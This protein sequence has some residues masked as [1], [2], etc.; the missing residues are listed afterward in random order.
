MMCT[1]TD[2]SAVGA[3]FRWKQHVLALH[4][5]NYCIY[6]ERREEIRPRKPSLP[7]ISTESG[8]VEGIESVIV[9]QGDIGVMIQQQRQHIVPFLRNCVMEGRVTF[10]ILRTKI[11]PYS[12]FLR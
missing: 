3:N 2:A 4:N 11:E 10:Q 5:E 7:W 12:A 6:K 8:M 9:G 1:E